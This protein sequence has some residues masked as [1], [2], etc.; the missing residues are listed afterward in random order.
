VAT[1]SITV[2]EICNKKLLPV[3]KRIHQ[4]HGQSNCI[5]FYL[6]EKSSSLSCCLN[7]CICVQWLRRKLRQCHPLCQS[8]QISSGMIVLLAR[9]IVRSYSS[10]KV[11]LSGLQALVVQVTKSPFLSNYFVA[12]LLLC[13][14]N[15]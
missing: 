1:S 2:Y 14:C 4:F 5:F 9:L 7:D 3:K 11:V 12:C 10:R 15:L 8:H 6:V 13:Q